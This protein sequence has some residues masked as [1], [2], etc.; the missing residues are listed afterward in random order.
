MS[1]SNASSL[2]FRIY[3]SCPNT[4]HKLAPLLCY[5]TR[6]CSSTRLA[7]ETPTSFPSCYSPD[8]PS[9]S[10]PRPTPTFP[11]FPSLKWILLVNFVRNTKIEGSLS[12][13]NR[14]IAFP[15]CRTD[16]GI[17][18]C[19]YPSFLNRNDSCHSLVSCPTEPLSR[20]NMPNRN[21]KE[22]SQEG[23]FG[24]KD[25][26][27]WVDSVERN[28][29]SSALSSDRSYSNPLVVSQGV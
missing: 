5:P 11:A 22:R 14:D 16:S 3:V 7:T 4:K 8:T 6:C 15:S 21:A 1:R 18:S 2:S 17:P 20:N 25:P 9:I 28:Q 27:A 29:V 10:W 26:I 24:C 13:H 12:L 23:I 19:F